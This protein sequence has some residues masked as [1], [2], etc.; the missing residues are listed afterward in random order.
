M[1]KIG[2]HF[3]LNYKSYWS[4]ASFVSFGLGV[5]LGWKSS[6]KSSKTGSP[7]STGVR[8]LISF[9]Y[10][11]GINFVNDVAFAAFGRLVIADRLLLHQIKLLDQ[12]IDGRLFETFHLTKDFKL[13]KKDDFPKSLEKISTK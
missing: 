2:D 12:A 1:S 6:I 5:R 13:I 8:V 10:G 7:R 9:A 11:L 3:T 4:V